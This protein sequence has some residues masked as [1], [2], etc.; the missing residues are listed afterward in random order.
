MTTLIL[1]GLRGSGKSTLG[2]L[3]AERLH[4]PFI[5]LDDRVMARLGHATVSQ[6]WAAVGEPAFR[7][8]ETEELRIVLES[9]PSPD[10]GLIL[11]LGGGT[12]TAPGAESL[13]KQAAATGAKLVYLRCTPEELRAR[14]KAAGG[15]GTNRPSLTGRDPLEEIDEV[16]ARRDP[17]YCSLAT[18]RIEGVHSAEQGVLGLLALAD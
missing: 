4:V 17:L 18:H 12:P 2:R 7:A 13:L 16:F 5:D 14:L 6:A 1:M 10:R 3:A 15:A 9:P 11:A 8:A